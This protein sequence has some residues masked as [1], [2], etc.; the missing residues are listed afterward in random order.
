MLCGRIAAAPPGTDGNASRS[1]TSPEAADAA[2]AIDVGVGG[3]ICVGSGGT[4]GW[5]ISSDGDDGSEAPWRAPFEGRVALVLALE[6]PRTGAPDAF[7]W[8]LP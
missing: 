1:N 4:G 7:L 6:E 5:G 3:R 8:A 2:D